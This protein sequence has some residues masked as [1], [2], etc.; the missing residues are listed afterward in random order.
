MS[1]SVRVTD[2]LHFGAMLMWGES[3][4]SQFGFDIIAMMQGTYEVGRVSSFY[5]M[6]TSQGEKSTSA[7]GG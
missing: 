1:T 4:F 3:N 6:G 5:G 2:D 7:P